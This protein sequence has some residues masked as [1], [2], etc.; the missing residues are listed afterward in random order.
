C[1]R[2]SR[3]TRRWSTTRGGSPASSRSRSSPSSSVRRRRRATSTAPWSGHMSSPLPLAAAG[4]VG[5][6]FFRERSTGTLPCQADQSH[7]FCWDWAKENIDRFGT[8]TLQH[9]QIVIPAIAI[10]FVV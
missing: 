1:C 3:S 10:G 2:E 5:G 8:P 7:L 6:D 9:L 4:E